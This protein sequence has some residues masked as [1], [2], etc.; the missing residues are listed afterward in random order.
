MFYL[1][2]GRYLY[3]RGKIPY[4]ALIKALSWQRSRRPSIGDIAV[5][6]GWLNQPTVLRILSL[7]EPRM[8]F[9]ERAIH[10]GI[11]TN[12]QVKTLLSYQ[13]RRQNKIGQYFVQQG[14]L[15]HTE[16]ER[17]VM[18]MKEHNARIKPRMMTA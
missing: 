15:S 2:L 9:G 4:S 18:E 8:H 12:F 11:F 7:K 6:W 5:S 14:L 13:H 17:M 1:E 16:M 10:L 3:Y